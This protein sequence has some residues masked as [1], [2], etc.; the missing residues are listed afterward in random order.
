MSDEEYNS[1]EAVEEGY[2]EEGYYVEEPQDDA[3]DGYDYGDEA[4]EEPEPEPEEEQSEEP[5]TEPEPEPEPDGNEPEEEYSEEPEAAEPDGN[6]VEEQ[7]E[8]VRGDEED[9]D[10]NRVEEQAVGHDTNAAE[11][12]SGGGDSGGGL[13][14]LVKGR[15]NIMSSGGMESIVEKMLGEAAHRFLG[16]NPETGAIIGAIAG[17]LIFNMGGRGNSLT[18]IGKV[19]LDNIISGK[20]K[21]DVHPFVPP[22]P[23]PGATSFGLNFQAE[24]DRCLASK[25]LFEDPE[26]PATDRSLYYKSPP[27]Q[28]VEWKRPGVSSRLKDHKDTDAD[29]NSGRLDWHSCFVF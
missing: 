3:G 22:V 20:Y 8:E 26:F 29:S 13:G 2:G 27:D 23:T 15:T 9:D 14:S 17:N 1:D 19:I 4:Y 24:R 5:E 11:D 28:H 6:E 18:S 25:T 21:R 16:I 12:P 10:W 7:E